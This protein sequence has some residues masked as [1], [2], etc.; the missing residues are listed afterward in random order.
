MF[1]GLIVNNQDDDGESVYTLPSSIHSDIMDDNILTERTP[2][3]GSFSDAKSTGHR[4]L[5]EV[6]SIHII[7]FSD[8]S[9]GKQPITCF[10]QEWH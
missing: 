9:I 3:M 8:L 1:N 5:E 2:K 6:N 7:D 4:E 10:L